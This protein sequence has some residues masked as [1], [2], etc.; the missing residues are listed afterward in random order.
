MTS[1]PSAAVNNSTPLPL[2][3]SSSV[4]DAGLSPPP[5]SLSDKAE[6]AKGLGLEK[7][8]D[9]E[10]LELDAVATADGAGGGGEK[11]VDDDDDER[12]T[13]RRRGTKVIPVEEAGLEIGQ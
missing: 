7:E 8:R 6:E 5:L 9:I 1:S 10:E 12:D 13:L 11:G 3:T 2:M 4:V